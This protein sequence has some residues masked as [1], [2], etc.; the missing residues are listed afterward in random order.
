MDNR[1]YGYR[2][3]AD[4]ARRTA[5][6]KRALVILAEADAFRGFG[7]DRREGL[8]AVRR[9]PDDKPL[10]LFARLS[11]PDQGAEKIA[12]LPAMPLSEHV[13]TDY[14]TIRLSLKGYP[15]QFLRAA[16][17]RGRHRFLQRRGR[18]CATAPRSAAPAWCWCASVRAKAPPS[19]SPCPTKPA[20]AMW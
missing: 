19:S 5:L 20:S 7:L 18:T 8:W 3:F 13:L 1:G 12:P 15:T 16:L 11:A 14:Q 6:P 9:L 10:P 17:R 4:F 2:D